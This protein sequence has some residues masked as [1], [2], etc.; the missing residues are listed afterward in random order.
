[1]ATHLHQGRRI[2]L[3]AV[4]DQDVC[5]LAE[6]QR[7]GPPW[8]LDQQW[9]HTPWHRARMPRTRDQVQQLTD[10]VIT[11]LTRPSPGS[12]AAADPEPSAAPA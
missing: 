12:G 1:M 8:T 7:G 4:L 11:W 2:V 3:E 10:E 5:F 6:A 9:G